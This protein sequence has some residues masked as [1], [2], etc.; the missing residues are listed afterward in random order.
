MGYA[1]NRGLARGVSASYR[2]WERK[3]NVI[4]KA[5]AHSYVDK[6]GNLPWK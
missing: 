1:N 4:H 6:H 2:H 3:D 5:I